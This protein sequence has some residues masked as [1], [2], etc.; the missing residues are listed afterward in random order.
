MQHSKPLIRMNIR[1]RVLLGMLLSV[2]A[3]GLIGTFSYHSL[4]QIER[5]M[6]FIEV[7]DDLGNTI[8]E[9]RRYE[10]NFMLYGQQEDYD[11]SREYAAKASDIL[12]KLEGNAAEFG[13]AQEHASLKSVLL[14]YEAMAARLSL[15]RD[16]GR[17]APQAERDRLRDTGKQLV[18]L[19]QRLVIHERARVLTIVQSLKRQLML[20]V[21]VFLAL[22]G[23]FLFVLGHKTISALRSIEQA[24]HEIAKGCFTALVP[25]GSDD[26]VARVVG[27]FNHMIAELQK[28]QDQ[29]VREKKLSSLGVLTSGVAH[30]LNNPLNNISTSCQIL[31]EEGPEADPGF[32]RK[33][34]GNIDGEVARARDIVKGLLEFS[35]A[36]EFE[37]KPT[38]LAEVVER[39]VRLVSSQVPAGVEIT[40]EVPPDLVLLMDAQRMQEVFL[41]LLINALQAQKD[42]TGRIAISAGRDEA[43]GQ[44]VISV[45]DTGAGIAEADL[46]HIFDPFFTTKEVGKGTGLGLSIVFGIVEQHQGS[47]SVESAP[48]QGTCFTLRLPLE[49]AAFACAGREA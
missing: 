35:R 30:Q 44:A 45:A 4:A 27:A 24:T 33:L 21:A 47:I 48:G 17:R 39:S 8:L 32:A 12:V 38:S 49:G 2:L 14:E 16:Q 18:D 7:I 26:E 13:L 37:R 29:L 20:S 28:R 36:K 11:A 31:M 6:G 5:K 46:A 15:V 25:S 10:K 42:K 1:R 3:V 43:Q 19:S 22:G 40:R 34:L 9:I 23:G 41:N